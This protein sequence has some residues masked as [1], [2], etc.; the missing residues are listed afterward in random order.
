MAHAGHHTARRGGGGGAGSA[1]LRARRFSRGH[2]PA[3]MT[4]SY[5][6]PRHDIGPAFSCGRGRRSSRDPVTGSAR[7]SSRVHRTKNG[8]Y[9][10]YTRTTHKGTSVTYYWKTD[11]G[12]GRTR[13]STA[14][15][16]ERTPRRAHT[17]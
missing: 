6:Y 16:D 15:K 2:D 8:R 7:R 10:M 11:G 4:R 14:T 17:D 9:H 3:V 1:A 5:E 12:G 13:R